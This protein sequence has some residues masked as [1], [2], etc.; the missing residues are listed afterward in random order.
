ME[1]RIE[2]VNKEQIKA[3]ELSLLDQTEGVRGVGGTLK[4]FENALD[5]YYQSLKFILKRKVYEMK[6]AEN[7]Y[8]RTRALVL[9]YL[10]EEEN[11][12][13]DPYLHYR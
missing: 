5:S 6:Q 13:E 2:E 3:L 10:P 11:L 8:Y 4:D 9:K 1:H 12:A 7:S